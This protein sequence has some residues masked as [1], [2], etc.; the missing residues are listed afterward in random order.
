MREFSDNLLSYYTGEFAGLNLTRITEPSEFYDKQIID[1]L[2][3]F[4]NLSELAEIAKDAKLIIDVGFGGGFPLIP[5]AKIFPEKKIIGI[6]A[7]GKKASAVQ[8][9]AQ[10][11]GLSNV[12]CFHA[13]LE[14]VQIDRD[15][16]VTFKAVGPIKDLLEMMNVSQKSEVWVVFYKGPKTYELEDVPKKINGS[17]LILEKNFGIEDNQRAIFLY[18][19]SRNVPRGTKKNKNKIVV[20]VAEID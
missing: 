13:R 14:E 9:I 4:Q 5:L 10:R 17:E 7:R 3:P 18:K 6:D 11:V 2:Y 19:F 16:I 20:K 8:T 15:C 12:K 1:S